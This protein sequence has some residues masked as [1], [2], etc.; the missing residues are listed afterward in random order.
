M[1]AQRRVDVV[2]VALVTFASMAVVWAPARSFYGGVI[3]HFSRTLRVE[4]SAFLLAA[5]TVP[6]ASGRGPGQALS[7]GHMTKKGKK[8]ENQVHRAPE[9]I[10]REIARLKLRSI[11]VDID[12]L[13][14]Q[15]KPNL[16]S[17]QEGT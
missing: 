1:Q 2:L 6:F 7:A 5:A 4:S 15:H 17:W 11:G 14:P 13:T 8:L 12:K 10:D 16:A 9:Q 3:S